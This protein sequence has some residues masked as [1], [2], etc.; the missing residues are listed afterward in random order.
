[1]CSTISLA[2]EHEA[3]G[4]SEKTGEMVLLGEGAPCARCEAHGTGECRSGLSA[5]RLAHAR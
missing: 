4:G 5:G 1:M 3:A 2:D